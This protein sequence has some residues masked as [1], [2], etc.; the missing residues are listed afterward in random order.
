MGKQAL[1]GLKVVELGSYISAPFSTRIMADLG[2][3]VIKVEPP[4]GDI[5][6]NYGPFPGDRKDPESSGIFLYLNAGKKGITL[7]L[8]EKKDRS[9]FLE[10]V[11]DAD[12][13]VENTCAS[14]FL[15]KRGLDYGSLEKVNPGLV[16]VSISPFGRTG[17]YRDYRG[18]DIN[19]SALAGLSIVLGSP[20][21]EPLVIPYSQCDFQGALHAASAALTALL[22]RRKTGKGQHVD[23]SVAEVLLYSVRG[24]YFVAKEANVTWMRKGTRQQVSIYPTGY[25]P[26]K[27]G[28]VC[29]ASQSPKQWKKFI[30]L[31]G[32]PEWAQDPELQD[33]F[34]LGVNNPDRGDEVFHPW[35]KQHTRKELMQLAMEHGLTMGLVN[36][37][38][39]MVGDPHFVQRG[40]WAEIEAPQ[41]GKIRIPGMSYLMS[42]TPW[43]IT[44]PAPKLGEYNEEVLGG[45]KSTK[46]NKEKIVDG[47]GRT[48]KR[49]LEGYRVLDFGWNWA[50]PQAA[51]MM[52]DMGAE[53]I[54][55]ESRTR[56]DIMRLMAYLKHFFRQNNRNKLSVT[57]DLK[58]SEGVDLL[59]RLVKVSDIVLDNF[60]AGIMEKLGIGYDVLEAVNPGIICISMS[61]AGQHGPQRDM[62]GF[63]SIA[64]GYAGLEGLIG[65]PGEGSLGLMSFGYGDI[66]MSIQGVYS[67]LAALY[68][69]EQTGRGQFID[70]SQIEATIATMGEPVLDYF[71]NRRVA[72]PQGNRHP[73]MAPYGN[74]PTAGED[75][76][77]SIAVGSEEEWKSFTKAIGDPGWAGE[78]RFQTAES[79]LRN[80]KDLDEFV[81]QWTR[82]QTRYEAT[83]IL[84]KAGVAAAPVVGIED[85]DSDP[86]LKSRDISREID[87]PD[88]SVGTLYATPWK[89]SDTPGGI[90]RLTPRLGEHNEYVYKELLGISDEEFN[91]LVEAG[92]IN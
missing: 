69:R 49:P 54:K 53:V 50:G 47:S 23:V 24:M 39:E 8:E 16:M 27:D 64:T 20:G 73:E 76:W 21:R 81:S 78:K 91:R 7:D 66:N 89:L 17:P 35:L 43:R 83:E 37:I 71:L 30:K 9:L 90:D 32:E 28:Y 87:H 3:D 5:S 74:Y 84:Q 61:M 45:S 11:S 36:R 34:S 33:G 72:E 77:I 52:A 70:V 31:M 40:F 59:K 29:I 82:K 86:Q 60:S 12:V 85:G 88:Y 26:C 51:Q 68:Y 75:Q 15:E 1:E 62:K 13:L 46:K 18:H 19:S 2:A 22:A 6:R 58:H 55:I 48:L 42:E 65:Y 25:F 4:S 56:Q 38:D 79:R 80:R 14:S 67:V 44:R 57:V 10:I 63:A 41:L 92:V